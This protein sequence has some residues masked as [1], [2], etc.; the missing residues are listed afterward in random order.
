MEPA[1][2]EEKSSPQE[3]MEKTHGV[4]KDQTTRGTS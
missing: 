1:K 2:K 4:R 3:Y